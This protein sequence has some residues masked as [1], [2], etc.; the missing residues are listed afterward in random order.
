M[1]R[2][3]DARTVRTKMLIKKAFAELIEQKEIE[4]ITVKELTERAGI[5]RGTFYIHYKDVYDII[6]QTKLEMVSSLEQEFQNVNEQVDSP[7]PLLDNLFELAKKDFWIYKAIINAKWSG[8]YTKSVKELIINKYFE[9]NKNSDRKK[10]KYILSFIISGA[11]GMFQDWVLSG[12]PFP[13]DEIHDI[14]EQYVTQVLKSK[15]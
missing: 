11:I 9:L 4:Q 1:Q 12:E 5:H 15:D 8:Q 6:E 10:D 2:R 14:L 7:I 13:M 3:N